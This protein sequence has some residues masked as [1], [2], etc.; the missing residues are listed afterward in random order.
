MRL[1]KR[2]A[3][4]SIRSLRETGFSPDEVLKMTRKRGVTAP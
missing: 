4:I 2:D 3:A 1:A